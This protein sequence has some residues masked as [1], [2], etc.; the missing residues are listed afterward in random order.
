MGCTCGFLIQDH[1]GA[2]DAANLQEDPSS[3]L[4]MLYRHPNSQYSERDVPQRTR[5]QAL[6]PAEKVATDDTVQEI[7]MQTAVA[8][9]AHRLALLE[10]INTYTDIL[11]PPQNVRLARGPGL[12]ALASAKM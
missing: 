2:V 6:E 11:V 5:T 12:D 10:Q 9:S 7:L 1:Q 3:R 8:V 4:M